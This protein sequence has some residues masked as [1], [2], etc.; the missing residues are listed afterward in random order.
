MLRA[1]GRLVSP[2]GRRWRWCSLR[3]PAGSSL[4]GARRSRW[5]AGL[6]VQAFNARMGEGS[7][8]PSSRGV[9][10]TSAVSECSGGI[11]PGTGVPGS[12]MALALQAPSN[13][14]TL[15]KGGPMGQV[16]G[17]EIGASRGESVG[18]RCPWAYRQGCQTR[19]V[20]TPCLP[21]S[22]RHR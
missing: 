18:E 21:S 15:S 11:F 4:A 14:S 19:Q 9:A 8:S 13:R 2:A 22:V 7:N 17:I 5:R 10:A 12:E 3:V 16:A 1:E 20:G 6:R